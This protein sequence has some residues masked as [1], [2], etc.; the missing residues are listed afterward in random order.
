MAYIGNTPADKYQTLEKQS[1]SVSATT[2]YTLSY[3]VSSPQDIALFINNVR[4]NPNSSYTVS[5]TALTLSSATSSGDVMYAVFLGKSVGTIAPASN[6]VTSSMMASGVLPTNT[7]AFRAN[8]SSNQSIS[9]DT[10]TKVAFATEA[11][12]TDGKYDTSN[13]RFTPTIAGKYLIYVR[14]GYQ[15]HNTGAGSLTDQAGFYSRIYVNGSSV[16]NVGNHSSV[17]SLQG[18]ISAVATAIVTLDNN[19]Y[20]EA[21]TLQQGNTNNQAAN[22]LSNASYNEF[23]GYRLIGV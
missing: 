11:L 20:V 12:D 1:F 22:L 15:E 13:Y 18:V 6:S 14:I 3:S 7:P 5:N 9:A 8:L 17:S 19:D 21:Y 23:G 2:G 10:A 4:Q 16:A